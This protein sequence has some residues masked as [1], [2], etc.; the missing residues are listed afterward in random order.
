MFNNPNDPRNSNFA[1]IMQENRHSADMTAMGNNLAAWQQA[2]ANMEDNR[3]KF[4]QAYDEKVRQLEKLQKDHQ[5]LQEKYDAQEKWVKTLE[6]RVRRWLTATIGERLKVKHFIKM[7]RDILT[8]IE[9]KNTDGFDDI[10][11]NAL[12]ADVM[13]DATLDLKKLQSLIELGHEVGHKAFLIENLSSE[14][15]EAHSQWI[16]YESEQYLNAARSPNANMYV[17]DDI[18]YFKRD[19]TQKTPGPD[20][21]WESMKK[22]R[23]QSAY[24]RH[25]L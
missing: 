24:Y 6:K 8:R 5:A 9:D 18:D 3:N 21:L 14:D 7:I 20:Q 19:K 11:D 25:E 12:V 13:K 1:R 2:Y 10:T 23:S 22:D 16:A 4:A 15:L 17:F